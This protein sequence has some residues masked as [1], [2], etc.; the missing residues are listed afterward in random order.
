MGLDQY[1]N[2]FGQVCK[3]KYGSRVR[4]L[5]LDAQFTCPN[6]D[7]TLGKGGCTFCNVASF[8]H[9]HGN[10]QSITD[11]L[12]EGRARLESKSA[13]Y[14]AYFQAYTSTYDEFKILKARYDEA[15]ADPH[16]VGLSVGTR[17]DCVSDEVIELLASY[18]ERGF[19][20][21]LELGLQTSD[22][23][24]LKRINR[25]HNFAAYADTVTRARLR[26]IKVCTHLILG[27]PGESLQHNLTSLKQVLAVGVDGLKIHPLHIVE[28][29]T[30]AKAWRAGR[31]SLLTKEEYAVNVGE[32]IRMT[33]KSII[34]HRVTAYAK[35]PMLLAPDWCSYRWEG[36][37]AIVKNLEQ[38]G[39]QGEGLTD[40]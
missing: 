21:W 24:T 28:G 11:Q 6:R 30:M 29:S 23:N 26:G 2:T 37:V 16:I 20:V 7:G 1:V 34:F 32:M 13:K 12:A 39:G 8:S 14:I 40:D 15:V 19:D 27:L 25:G 33:P 38:F 3:K 9:E 17:P 31:L 35:R 18:Q 5:T 4:K 22:D 10:Q 36:L